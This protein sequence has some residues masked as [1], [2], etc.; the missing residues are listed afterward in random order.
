[1][2]SFFNLAGVF[3]CALGCVLWMMARL[4]SGLMAWI[5]GA[6]FIV[7]AAVIDELRNRIARLPPPPETLGPGDRKP[8]R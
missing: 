5:A 2:V 8:K 7:G 6:I 4:D 3:F 1:V